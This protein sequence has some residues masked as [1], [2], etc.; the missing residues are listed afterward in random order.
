MGWTTENVGKPKQLECN[1]HETNVSNYQ[2]SRITNK[3]NISMLQDNNQL[4]ANIVSKTW[5]AAV[6]KQLHHISETEMICCYLNVATRANRVPF[7]DILMGIK[8]IPEN[9]WSK[10]AS[11]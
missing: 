10:T 5:S 3:G 8:K 4:S 6:S 7:K 2:R 11:I 9:M 1:I